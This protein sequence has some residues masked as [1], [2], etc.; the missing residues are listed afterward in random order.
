MAF[1]TKRFTNYKHICYSQNFSSLKATLSVPR[2]GNICKASC[3]C[4]M[5]VE[6]SKVTWCFRLWWKVFFFL[7]N[8]LKW[9]LAC[10]AQLF[11]SSL[12]FHSK[13][14]HGI[15]QSHSHYTIPL[16][17]IATKLLKLTDSGIGKQNRVKKSRSISKNG[18]PGTACSSAWSLG[19]LHHYL[20]F[21]PSGWDRELIKSWPLPFTWWRWV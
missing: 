20:Q 6:G 7:M 17:Q 4:G 10:L 12:S 14:Q 19:H 9:H 18:C 1:A 21:L 8:F 15:A 11:C 13:I 3:V 2:V 5:T 16:H